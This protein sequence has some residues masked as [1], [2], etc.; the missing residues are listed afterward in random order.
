MNTINLDDVLQSNLVGK[1]AI[2][3][4]GLLADIN[5]DKPLRSVSDFEEALSY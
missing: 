2:V 5:K 1:H 3:S 4:T